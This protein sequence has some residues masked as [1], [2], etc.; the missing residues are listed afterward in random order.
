[1]KSNPYFGP[2]TL[3][4][5]VLIFSTNGFWQAIAP[6]GATA[7]VIGASRLLIGGLT[8]S[9]WCLVRYRKIHLQG[10]DWKAIGIYAVALWLYQIFFFSRRALNRCCGRHR[11]CRRFNSDICRFDPSV[12]L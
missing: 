3:L 6:E 4:A 9:L 11:G 8:L 2:M 10:W 5:D 7:Y 12:S 1:M